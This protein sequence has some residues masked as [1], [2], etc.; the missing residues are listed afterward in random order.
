MY[1]TYFYSYL[2]Q[3][4][5]IPKGY[6]GVKAPLQEGPAVLTP[7]KNKNLYV[8]FK[9]GTPSDVPITNIAIIKTEYNEACPLSILYILYIYFYRLSSN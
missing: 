2:Q 3:I 9:Y 4:S 7:S 8:I 6:K 5:T 1:N